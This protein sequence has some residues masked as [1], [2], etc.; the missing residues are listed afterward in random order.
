[1]P[2]STRQTSHKRIPGSLPPIPH[3]L[4]TGGYLNRRRNPDASV[5]VFTTH[6]GL[7]QRSLPEGIEKYLGSGMVKGIGPIFAQRL[8]GKF[9]G[10][11]SSRSD[12]QTWMR[13]RVEVGP[14][15][16][17]VCCR[18]G[19]VYSLLTPSCWTASTLPDESSSPCGGAPGQDP[20]I[21]RQRG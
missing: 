9:G 20:G 8:V 7:H 11:R 21:H 4:R 18:P 17:A 6:P 2:P 15:R 1:M 19:N 5:A 14:A 13:S 10:S 12:G 3:D 16:E